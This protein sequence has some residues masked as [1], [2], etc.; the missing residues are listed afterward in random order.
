MFCLW[1]FASGTGKRSRFALSN[2]FQP[3]TVRSLVAAASIPILLQSNTARTQQS[4][5]H[6]AEFISSIA[7]I[8]AKHRIEH[9]CLNMKIS[10]GEQRLS[11]SCLSIK[12]FQPSA[13]L[14]TCCSLSTRSWRTSRTSRSSLEFPRN[15]FLASGLSQYVCTTIFDDTGPCLGFFALSSASTCA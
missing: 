4:S 10:Y 3:A 13:V 2:K 14:L 1:V 15:S 12:S 8:Y 5:T 11:L 7:H 6:L 9:L